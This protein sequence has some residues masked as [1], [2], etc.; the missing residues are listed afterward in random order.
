M[1]LHRGLLR[2]LSGAFTKRPENF[3][4]DASPAA[5]DL[6]ARVFEGLGAAPL[7]DHHVHVVGLGVGGTGNFVNPAMQSWKNPFRRL[8]YEA[9]LSGA[10]IED[11]AAADR[12][13]FDRLLALA[14]AFPRPARFHLLA[15][16]KHYR[17]DGSADLS[18]TEMYVP[19]EYVLDLAAKHSDLF[20]ATISVH[21]YRPDALE[22]LE[23]GARRG[24]R[25][26]KWLPN[27]MG[28]DP[29]DPRCDAFYGK[30]RTFGLTLLSH[31]G[32]EQAVHAKDWQKNGNPLRL[33]RALDRGVRVIA[34]HCGSLGLDEDLDQP[35][36]PKVPSFDLF[37]R[38]M[39][40]RRYEGLLFG[41][42]SAMTQYNRIPKP[43]LAL[44]ERPE[45]HTRLVNGSDYPLPAI[46]MLIHTKKFVALKMISES[47]RAALNEI[48]DFNPML[49]DFVLK[50]TMRHPRTGERVSGGVFCRSF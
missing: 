14:R 24:A 19:N 35:G 16:D 25:T 27:A 23:K 11:E 30:M 6:L 7:Q 28:M 5:R 33:R 4:R 34:A 39:G 43:L 42:L 29:A 44:L 46:N 32:E 50:R 15:F 45:W 21:P 17:P 22:E 36:A 26:V 38:L 2:R 31:T 18:N 40:E 12:Q 47:E 48:Y 10:A 8:R 3:A 9:Y 1:C 13:Y 49:F 20:A 41:E 37:L